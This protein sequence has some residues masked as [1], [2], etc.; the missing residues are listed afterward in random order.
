[1]Q[2]PQ[3]LKEVSSK[4]NDVAGDGT[5][6]ASVLA[7]AIVREGL[8]T[9]LQAQIQCVMKRGIDKGVVLSIE[10]IKSLSKKV[11][12]QEEIAQVA[13]ISAGKQQGNRRI[14]RRSYGKS[15]T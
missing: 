3:L 2:E 12:I 4:T 9:L 13:T 8:K 10:K 14:H 11:V 1:M 15:R 7:Q 5:T 6:T